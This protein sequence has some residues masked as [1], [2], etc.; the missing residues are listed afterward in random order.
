MKAIHFMMEELLFK[1][2]ELLV[3]ELYSQQVIVLV[4]IDV[5]VQDIEQLLV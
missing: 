3:L 2:I 5:L 1:V 4:L